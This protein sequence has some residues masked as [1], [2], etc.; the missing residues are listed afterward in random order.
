VFNGIEDYSI[1]RILL[2]RPS[3][4]RLDR[5][6]VEVTPAPQKRDCRQSVP[7][8]LRISTSENVH[9]CV[10]RAMNTSR[11]HATPLIDT[12]ALSTWTSYITIRR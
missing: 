6:V 7:L 8:N 12:P 1:T 2:N 9:P 5:N 3:A 4:V 10:G 11:A